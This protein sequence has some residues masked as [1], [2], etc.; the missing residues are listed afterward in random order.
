MFEVQF[1]SLRISLEILEKL[2]VR[3]QLQNSLRAAWYLKTLFF[4][5]DLLRFRFSKNELLPFDP[6]LDTFFKN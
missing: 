6:S 4:R 3:A 1:H 2:S 5:K